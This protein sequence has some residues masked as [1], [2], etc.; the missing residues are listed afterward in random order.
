MSWRELRVG[1]RVGRARVLAWSLKY[2]TGTSD[3]EG[4]WRPACALACLHEFPL[5][6]THL[7]IEL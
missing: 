5:D 7:K 6:L 4:G 1:K 3:T 2:V